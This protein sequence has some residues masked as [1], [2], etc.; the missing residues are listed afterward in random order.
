MRRLRLTPEA[1][2]VVAGWSRTA[3]YDDR[4]RIAEFVETLADGSWDS[5]R[6]WKSEVPPAEDAIE[7]RPDEGL[8]VQMR[9]LV[10]EDDGSAY[11]DVYWIHRVRE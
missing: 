6:W 9:L 4:L 2:R 3:A 5:G 1:E 7:F 10:D 11:A 8:L